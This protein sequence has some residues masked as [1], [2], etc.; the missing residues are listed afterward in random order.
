[1]RLSVP[2]GDG[3]PLR[4]HLQRLHKNTRRLDPQLAASLREFPPAI[5]HIWQAFVSLSHTR[6]DGPIALTEIEAWQRLTGV[7][8][9]AWEFETLQAMDRAA[10]RA[11][12][13][14]RTARKDVSQ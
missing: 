1:M 11:A 12:D 7:H 14:S 10:L 2:Q 8:L 9:S 6:G 13:E 3:V 5:A 4:I